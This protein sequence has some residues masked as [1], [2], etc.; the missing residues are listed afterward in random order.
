MFQER[1]DRVLKIVPSTT[2]IADDV[3]CHKNTEIPHDAAVITLLETARADNLTFNAETLSSSLKTGRS[4]ALTSL[5][6]GIR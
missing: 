2:G 5:H 1:L 4:L 6:M 3:L